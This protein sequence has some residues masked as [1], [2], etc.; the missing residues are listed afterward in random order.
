MTI[1]RKGFNYRALY[2]RRVHND[3][4]IDGLFSELDSMLAEDI[5]IL[6]PITTSVA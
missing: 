1:L 3:N 6:G 5:N 4:M 2:S